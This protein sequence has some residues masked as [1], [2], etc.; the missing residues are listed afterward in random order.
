MAEKHNIAAIIIGCWEEHYD[1][2][3]IRQCYKNINN[4]IMSNK[5]I[6]TVW[7]SGNHVPI[8]HNIW[9][10]NS[11]KIFNKEQ[12]VDWVRRF[13]F[14]DKGEEFVNTADV[15]KWFHYEGKTKLLLWEQWQI[16]WLLNHSFKHIDTLFYFGIGWNYGVKRD[17]IGW[18]QICDS[19]N[20]GHIKNRK[21]VTK[22]NCVLSN[23]N[24]DPDF[25]KTTFD[26]PNFN[27]HNWKKDSNYYVKMDLN[28]Q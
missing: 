1:N 11:D 27:E 6:E 26:V 5:D 3:M 28:W 16:E 4:E 12:G 21:L 24:T 15:I 10:E 25:R 19:I 17:P 7:L 8:E 23:K 9:Y 18:G 2:P 14:L 13:W 20:Y 22:E